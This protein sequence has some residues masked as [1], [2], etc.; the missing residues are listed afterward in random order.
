MKELNIA[1]Y[2]SKPLL[3]TE[4][5]IISDVIM[6]FLKQRIDVACIVD[7]SN[8][9]LGIVSKYS[10]YRSILAGTSLD[11]P[12]KSILRRDVLTVN[13]KEGFRQVKDVLLQ[14]NVAH[15]IV[16]NQENKV[17]G[18]ISKSDIINGFLHETEILVNQLTG[19]IEN[20]QDIVI[21]IDRNNQIV[22]FN[23]A[24]EKVMLL[25]KEDIIGRNIEEC[26]PEIAPYMVSTL[27][28]LTTIKQKK[29]TL[30]P[31]TGIGSFIPITYKEN[32]SGALAIIKDITTL[33]EFAQEL[34][35]T[36]NL[37]QT[38][39]QAM[40][41]SYDAVIITDKQGRI[42]LTNQAF[43]DLFELNDKTIINKKIEESVPVL[44]PFTDDPHQRKEIMT[45]NN[46][47]GIV[48]KEFIVHAGKEVGMIIKI[49][50]N[51]LDQWKELFYRMDKLESELNFYRSEYQKLTQ[52]SS[53]DI[54]K[55]NDKKMANL[56]H[57]AL[58][59]AKNN[60]T[61]LI[62]GES[63]TGKELFAEAVHKESGR[64]GNFVKVNCAAI[65]SELLE[66]E[67]FGYADG[68]FTGARR[69]GKVGKFELADKG[70]LFLDEIGD[71]PLALQS[72]LL[73]VLQ[74]RNFE[75][76]GDNRTRT[77]DVRIIA[78]TNKDLYQ[79]VQDGEFREDFYYRIN[80]VTIQIP[81]L[82]ERK[83]DIPLLCNHLINK[84]NDRLNK[85]VIGISPEAFTIIKEYSWPGNIRQLENIL[86]RAMNFDVK[87]WIDT[88]H[89][90]LE[91][92]ENNQS[93]I[94]RE[95]IPPSTPPVVQNKQVSSETVSLKD[96]EKSI[97]M[98][99]LESVQGNRSKAA[100]LLGISRTTLYNKLKKYN[101][102]SNVYFNIK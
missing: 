38:L 66:S 79:L 1:D 69:G 101:I 35:T 11:T 57:Q 58:L 86:E 78:A 14:H 102:E 60:S 67:F 26:F 28:D 23:G 95:F 90:P 70:T 88:I 31:I 62:T 27:D 12:L 98:E 65:P 80:V 34:E 49:I 29:V 22:A 45:I 56:K 2:Y 63:G 51:Q 92:L 43:L 75:R 93:I 30:G 71:M 81:P 13:D 32:T 41:L 52:N 83:G 54:I 15:G 53:F 19:L 39:Q 73:R 48:T 89:L 99:T 96:S 7:D 74:E 10:V 55:S 82:R 17:V 42:T 59:S 44:G 18:V 64:K 46:K 21:S 91:L 3:L 4:N 84:L 25:K 5:N 94:S 87:N 100:D 47:T 50:S 24:A 33:E 97:I 20:L 77:V 76:I 16:L 37:Q 36:K 40:A 68:A 6:G 8:Y 85:Q 9:P 72:K 61:V